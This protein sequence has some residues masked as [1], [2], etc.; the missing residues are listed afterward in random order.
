MPFL[1]YNMTLLI[2]LIHFA[3][4]CSLLYSHSWGYWALGTHPGVL[5]CLVTSQPP[6]HTADSQCPPTPAPPLAFRP[7]PPW[8]EDGQPGCWRTRES[9]LDCKEFKPVNS[10]GNWSW[11]F[12]RRSDAE[13]PIL[14]PSD[15]KSWL[16]R[17]DPD[18]GKVWRHEEKGMTEDEIVEWYHWLN[19]H[20]LEQAPADGEGQGTL[21]CCSPW[22]S[23]NQTH[24]SNWTIAAL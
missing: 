20:E 13:A 21:A 7:G 15:A 3:C 17:K 9:P 5:L 18:G 10:K 12:I 1:L 14:W 11:I 2:S 23:Q 6:S 22:W 16:I 8:Q 4:L 24:L 19:W